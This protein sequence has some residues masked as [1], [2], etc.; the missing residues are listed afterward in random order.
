[1]VAGRQAPGLTGRGLGLVRLTVSCGE[2]GG[3]GRNPS[4]GTDLQGRGLSAASLRAEGESHGEKGE[5]YPTLSCHE[6]HH[7]PAMPAI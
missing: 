4:P 1:M 6:V 2:D 3:G 7:K 5:G